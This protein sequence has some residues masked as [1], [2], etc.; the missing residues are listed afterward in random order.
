M[1]IFICT[2][3]LIEDPELTKN[4]KGTDIC[5]FRGAVG[6]TMFKNEE[7]R[8]Y[9]I[10]KVRTWGDLA[11][12]C[13]KYLSKDSKVIVRGYIRLYYPDSIKSN[14]HLEIWAEEVDLMF[15]RQ[16]KTIITKEKSDKDKNAGRIWTAGDE[17]DYPF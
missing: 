13:A 6:R 2:A 4:K 10:I 7:G 16:L 15:G 1:Q 3:T 17:E 5:T 8:R 12:A 14:F 11:T 9:D